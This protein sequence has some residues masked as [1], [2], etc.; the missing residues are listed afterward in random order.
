MTQAS[1]AFGDIVST[2]S[3]SHRIG[4]KMSVQGHAEILLPPSKPLADGS[5]I[6]ALM[7]SRRWAA[8]PLGPP[9]GWPQALRSAVRLALSS[10][11]AMFLAWGPDL[12]LVYNDAGAVIL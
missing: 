2:A 3:D 6:G 8:S 5:E 10:K 1:W 12:G 11:F 9:D 4:P 7:G